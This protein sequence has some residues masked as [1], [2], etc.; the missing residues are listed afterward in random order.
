MAK[1]KPLTARSLERYQVYR[2]SPDYEYPIGSVRLALYLS[3]SRV[4]HIYVP[5]YHAPDVAALTRLDSSVAVD[6][7]RE[8][9]RDVRCQLRPQRRDGHVGT[10]PP[11]AKIFRNM[12]DK[13]DC[14]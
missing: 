11:D 13:F 1:Y 7:T 14:A 4:H 5:A 3:I 6:A 10:H 12:V 8:T 9:T 2:I